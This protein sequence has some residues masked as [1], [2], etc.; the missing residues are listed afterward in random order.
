A[1][2]D[3]IVAM[4]YEA[5]DHAFYIVRLPSACYAFDP[6][7]SGEWHTRITRESDTWRYGYIVSVPRVG[8]FLGDF[9]SIGFAKMG[10]DYHSEHMPSVSTM[11]TEIVWR[12]TVYASISE[13]IED[14]NSIRLEI[15]P[16]QGLAIGQ[17]VNPV[18][19]MRKWKGEGWT[20]WRS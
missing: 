2:P 1:D 4:V 14:V 8:I 5:D 3:L 6:N 20:N 9:A 10:N 12:A 15:A 11:G 17:G 7:Q 18:A 13:G 19:Q 16:G